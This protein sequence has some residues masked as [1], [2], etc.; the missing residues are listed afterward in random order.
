MPNLEPF[1]PAPDGN[2]VD[3]EPVDV[4]SQ[5]A[6]EN[7]FEKFFDFIFFTLDLEFDPTINQILHRSNHVETGRDRFNR[8]TEAN[9]LNPSFVENSPRHH[10]PLS[11]VPRLKTSK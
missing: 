9:S 3:D 10:V 2:L 4:A 1:E 7:G 5:M 8:I 6:V 11:P